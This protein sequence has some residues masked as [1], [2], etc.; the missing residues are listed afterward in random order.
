MKR[1]SIIGLVTLMVL[2]SVACGEAEPTATPT[3]M[4]TPSPTATAIP[5]VVKVQNQDRGGSGEYKFVPSEFNFEVGETVT[6][7]ITAET[8]FHTFTVDDLDINESLDPGESV[9][10][11]VTFDKAGNFELI[12]IPHHGHGM[13]GT[14]V[15]E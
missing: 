14:I 7:E 11:T 8:E 5:G 4:V 1:Y 6:F 13:T 15:V 10:L 9:T 12:C 3:S 2:S